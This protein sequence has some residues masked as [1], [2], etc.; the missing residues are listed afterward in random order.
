MDERVAVIGL[1]YVGLPVALAFAR[2]AEQAIGFDIDPNRVAELRAGQDSS[3]A[4]DPATLKSSK[5]Q[6]TDRGEALAGSNF[7]VVGVPTPV[8][9]EKRPDLGPLAAACRSIAGVLEPGAMV[10]IESTVYPGATE[11]L[12]GPILA[13]SSGLVQGRDFQLAYSPERINPGDREHTLQQVVKIVAAEDS[14]GL[15]RV[16]R[17]YGAIVEAG[18]H[19]APS[20]KVAEAAKVIENT[21]R[22]LNIALMNEL[23][24]IF[25]RLGI[26]TQAVLEAAGSKWNFLPFRPGLVGG[27]CIGV[28]PYY[29][30][31]R[32]V[33]SGYQ[34]E[35]ILAGRR[36]N[37]EMGRVVARKTVRLLARSGRCLTEARVGI[38]GLTFKE[39]VP[40]LRNSKVVDLVEELRSFAVEPLLHDVLADAVEVARLFGRKPDPLIALDCLDALILAVP[41]A[42]YRAMGEAEIAARI[43]DE[44]IFIDL[45][46][47]FPEM[48]GRDAPLYWAL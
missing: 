11:E 43:A 47:A 25:D 33:Q 46:S 29:L 27:H 22:D 18:L 1:G 35:V 40:D 20:I 48:R 23:S 5:L 3:G 28:D 41:H 26:P 15:N 34:P 45:K 9:R 10:V 6:V 4:A 30:T 17:A 31:S 14:A 36:I 44:G 2:V 38:L 12:C 37:D 21:Q 13:E 32:A 24:L 42:A 8:D 39:D 16:A 7:F 19:R